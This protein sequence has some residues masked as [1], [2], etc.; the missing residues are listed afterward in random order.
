MK[1]ILF[2]LLI[3]LPVAVFAQDLSYYLSAPI[4]G[5]NQ[6]LPKVTD[7]ADY[8][9][10][11]FPFILSVAA[12]LALTMF[13]IAGIEYMIS[14]GL[15][16]TNDAK[17]R[18]TSALLGLGLAVFSVLILQE[19]NP[20]LVT[21]T[22]D[23]E[24]IKSAPGLSGSGP[25]PGTPD[26]PGPGPGTPDGPGT[27][28]VCGGAY[29]GACST[30]QVCALCSEDECPDAQS[31]YVCKTLNYVDCPSGINCRPCTQTEMEACIRFNSRATECTVIQL[32]GREEKNCH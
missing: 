22:L 17:D 27:T 23:L 26:G 3:V 10:Y 5:I 28:G 6:K 14:S 15:E 1:K 30:G 7:L 16:K 29:S 24:Q 9:S 12:I 32:M 18:I 25:G 11:L 31:S 4:P 13:V 19:I 20:K 2:I 21:L 8:V